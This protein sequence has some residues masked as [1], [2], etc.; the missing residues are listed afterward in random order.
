MEELHRLVAVAPTRDG[1]DEP[2][3]GMRVLPA[4]LAQAGGITLDVSGVL[5][6]AVEGR[7]EQEDDAG[8]APDEVGAG[9]VQGAV[10]ETRGHGAGERGPRLRDGVDATVVV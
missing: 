9:R 7:R 4:V 1:H 2:E 5:R 8:P 10:R 6:R 3:G